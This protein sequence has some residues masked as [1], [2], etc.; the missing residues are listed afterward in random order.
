MTLT[1]DGVRLRVDDKL[2]ID[3]WRDMP[4]TRNQGTVYLSQGNHEENGVEIHCLQHEGKAS[5]NSN[6]ASPQETGTA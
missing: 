3:E 4:P 5:A 6:M 2:I 1:D